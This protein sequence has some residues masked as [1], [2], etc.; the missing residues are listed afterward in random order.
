MKIMTGD[1]SELGED[2][3]D[4]ETRVDLLIPLKKKYAEYEKYV[5]DW[6]ND[7]KNEADRTM[8]LQSEWKCCGFT[9]FMEFINQEKAE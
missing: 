6:N 4:R 8:T 7:K 1:G 3:I 5:E 2:T 9:G